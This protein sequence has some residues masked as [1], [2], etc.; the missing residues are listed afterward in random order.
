MIHAAKLDS[1]PR[2]QRFLAY[3]QKVGER[4]ATG[5]ELIAETRNMNPHTSKA[6]LKANGI[7]LICK[8]D[9]ITDDRSRVYRYWLSEFYPGEKEA[10]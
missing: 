10:A 9:R 1:S 7:Q 2:L 3:L 4:G 5:L 8:L 6:E